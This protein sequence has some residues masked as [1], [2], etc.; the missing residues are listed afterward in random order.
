MPDVDVGQEE[1][2]RHH[3]GQPEEEPARR[4]AAA[5]HDRPRHAGDE[6]AGDGEPGVVAELEV[7][8]ALGGGK[9][10]RA[11]G[12]QRGVGHQGQ[13]DR[14][15]RGQRDA[16]RAWRAVRRREVDARPR[17][18]ALDDVGGCH[19]TTLGMAAAPTDQPWGGIG[20]RPVILSALPRVRVPAPALR[21]PRPTPPASAGCPWRHRRAS[22]SSGRRGARCRCRRSPGAWS[23]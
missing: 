10:A 3:D 7:H 17:Q 18:D 21:P 23:A 16:P 2:Q 9:E 4:R 8:V 22:W 13:R 14:Q 5:R 1:H 15:D 12:D 11:D 19:G 6:H 20:R